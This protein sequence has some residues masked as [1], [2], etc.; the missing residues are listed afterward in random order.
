MDRFK[1]ILV[2]ASPGHLEPA[3][4]RAAAELAETSRARLT[5]LDVVEPVGRL[6]RFAM[7]RRGTVDAHSELV[8]QRSERLHRLMADTPVADGAEVKVLV[9]Q[10]CI[11]VIRH[12]LEHDN[13][14]VIVGGPSADGPGAPDCPNG[15]LQLLRKCPAAVWVMRPPQPGAS[16]ILALVDPDSDDP[17]RDGLNGRVLALAASLAGGDHGELHVG[18]ALERTGERAVRSSPHVRPSHEVADVLAASADA[19]HGERLGSLLERHDVAESGAEVHL[20]E[21]HAGEVLPELAHGL[22]TELI[23]MGTVARTGISGVIIGNLAETI[24]RSVQ[25]SVLAV[26]PDGFVAPVGPTPAMVA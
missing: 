2:A 14:L 8:R 4:L 23:V 10:P 18:H 11:E 6:R 19:V 21:G 26:K 22:S 24:L 5:I 20:V 13:D 1:R 25:C 17:A 3:M 15:V 16:R 7:V 12:V 9:G